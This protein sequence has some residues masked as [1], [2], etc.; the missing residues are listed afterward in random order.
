MDERE[1]LGR[2][3]NKLVDDRR[4]AE[5]QRDAQCG[6]LVR[7]PV[8]QLDPEW[9]RMRPGEY[10]CTVICWVDG[11][12]YLVAVPPYPKGYKLGEQNETAIYMRAPLISRVP[13]GVCCPE[14]I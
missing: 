5:H 6:R 13:A 2:E 1:R 4:M 11:D 10:V 3:L 8:S 9:R 12:H 7:V 14:E